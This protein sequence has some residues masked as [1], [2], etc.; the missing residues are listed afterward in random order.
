IVTVRNELT[1]AR[2]ELSDSQKA[3]LE[4]R[5]Q[6]AHHA[7]GKRCERPVIPHRAPGENLPLSYA[8][9]RL[10]FLD[11]LEQGSSVYN[12]CQA[13]RLTGALNATALERSLNEII[14]RHEVLRANFIDSD[15]NPAQTIAGNRT[16]KLQATDLSRVPGGRR[17]EEL[18]LALEAEARK[19]F[20][21]SGD[22]L[23]RALL[24]QLEANEHVL[25]ITMHHIVSDGWSIG[26]LFRELAAHYDSFRSGTLPALPELPIQYT[27]YALWERDSLRGAA[28]ER[29]LAYWRKQLSG[30]LPILD[31]PTDR[32]RPA[33][34]SLRGA[35]ETLQLQPTLTQ[36]LKDLSRQEGVPFFMTLLAALQTFLHRYTRQ[37]DVLVGSVVAGRNQLDLENLI[38]FFVNTVVFRSE[39]RRVGKECRS[40]WSP[41]H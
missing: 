32:A 30:T 27:D 17:E 2:R 34:Q 4:K 11:R 20:D 16:L 40:R 21:L 28:L 31:L 33:V 38:G 41:Y 35:S 7:G 6:G 9:Q 36:A 25:Q 3:L 18:R 14:R 19:P 10:W 15:G 5:L 1:L 23:L 12:L 37:E 26:V 8:Q 39:E 29:Q 22:L 13:V 24:I